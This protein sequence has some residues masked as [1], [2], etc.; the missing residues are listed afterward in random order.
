MLLLRLFLFKFVL[1]SFCFAFPLCRMQYFPLFFLTIFVQ[2]INVSGR[3]MTFSFVA[4]IVSTLTHLS[5]RVFSNFLFIVAGSVHAICCP[6]K[7]WN[8]FDIWSYYL[9]T[10]L[11]SRTTIDNGSFLT[12]S[13][14]PFFGMW[15]F[16]SIDCHLLNKFFPTVIL[17]KCQDLDQGVYTTTYHRLTF[18]CLFDSLLTV[19]PL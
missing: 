4:I 8:L 3:L 7:V 6:T 12:S 1:C 9:L 13:V 5:S 15:A 19:M 16:D 11:L 18:I 17:I 2:A 14:H 10:V